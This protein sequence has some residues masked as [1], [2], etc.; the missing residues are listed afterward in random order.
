M[1][2][3]TEYFMHSELALAAYSNLAA[4]MS[5][6]DYTDALQDGGKGMS[7]AQ[8]TAFAAT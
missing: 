8:A 5:G 2:M 1:S 6:K 3:I 7:A 4:G